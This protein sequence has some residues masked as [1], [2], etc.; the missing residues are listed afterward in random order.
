MDARIL[1]VPT[2]AIGM[3]VLGKDRRLNDA[4]VSFGA[5]RD[6]S[7]SAGQ[8]GVMRCLCLGIE[9]QLGARNASAG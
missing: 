1:T 4:Y 5:T 3:E 2:S 9:P 7:S 6:F 8:W